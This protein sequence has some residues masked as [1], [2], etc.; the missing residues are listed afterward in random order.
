MAMPDLKDDENIKQ[1]VQVQTLCLIKC[2]FTQRN[3]NVSFFSVT[4]MCRSQFRMKLKAILAHLISIANTFLRFI[5]LCCQQKA[6]HTKT[7]L[8]KLMRLIPITPVLP[9][10][11]LSQPSLISVWS[12]PLCDTGTTGQNRQQFLQKGDSHRKSLINVSGA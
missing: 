2:Y 10:I 11:L 3:C 6:S 7:V 5:S 4:A 1:H 12:V 9:I 8:H